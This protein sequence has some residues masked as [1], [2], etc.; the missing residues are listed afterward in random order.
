VATYS[1]KTLTLLLATL[2]AILLATSGCADSASPVPDAGATRADSGAQTH[3]ASASNFAYPV[4]PAGGGLGGTYPNPTVV[5]GGPP[6]GTAGGDLSGSYPNP[7]VASISGVSP[8][9]ITPAELLWSSTTVAPT[10]AQAS[11]G[12][13]YTP[14]SINVT[15]QTPQGG[16]GT[17]AQNTP[18]GLNLITA[19]PG[20]VGTAGAEAGYT[21]TRAGS[22]V[23][24]L[25][26]RLGTFLGG[27]LYLGPTYQPS[28]TAF[29]A[30]QQSSGGLLLNSPSGLINFSIASITA[31]NISGAAVGFS[32][33]VGGTST[34]PFSWNGQTTPNTVAC[35]T[36]GTQTI[37][38]GQAVLPFFLVSA[39]VLTSACTVDFSTNAAT[40]SFHMS[41]G[42]TTAP[43][44]TSTDLAS[45]SLLLKNGT[46]TIT[47]TS[48]VLTALQATGKNGYVVDTYGTNNITLE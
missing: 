19:A 4:G 47:V 14:A 26:S 33:P 11:Q 1:N 46:T 3:T 29:P 12:V 32:L 42:S 28:G 7:L 17:A 2:L 31:V 18:G 27:A 24:F 30:I 8:I 37:S 34:T 43:L 5:S 45:F 36:G 13:V 15:P 22:Q 44:V 10:I 21:V 25:G 6:S 35:G 48:A 38:A 16:S 39:S 20:A 9:D 41:F 40:G 23:A